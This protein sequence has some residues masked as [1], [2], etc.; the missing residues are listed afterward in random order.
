M[1]LTSHGGVHSSLE[2]VYEFL[3]VAA[4]EG[5]DK[6][7]VH[8]FMDGRDTDPR[9]GRGFLEELEGKMAETTGKI[10][11]VCGRFYAMDR[12]KRWNRVKE[13]YE[14][15]NIRPPSMPSRLRTMP[16]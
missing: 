12:D 6:V 3:S 2:H 10:A 4:Q 11:T 13:A 5:L 16:T 15:P 14:V 7:Y 1:G 9:S 8:A